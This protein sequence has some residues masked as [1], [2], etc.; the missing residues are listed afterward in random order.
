LHSFISQA[1][2]DYKEKYFVSGTLR[3]DGSSV[4]G[5]KAGLDGFPSIGAAWRMTEE[6]FM[7][8]SK[9]ADGTQA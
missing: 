7:M 8:N 6:N 1:N 3:R 2:Y 5:P 4:F 9:W